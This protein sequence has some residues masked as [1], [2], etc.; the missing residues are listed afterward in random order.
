MVPLCGAGQPVVRAL[1]STEKSTS[2]R[3]QAT[4]EVPQAA[5]FLQ[6]SPF[7]LLWAASAGPACGV[8]R[9]AGA[10]LDNAVWGDVSAV[11]RRRHIAQ[12]ICQ[13]STEVDPLSRTLPWPGRGD[14]STVDA[15]SYFIPPTSWQH[16]SSKIV[17]PG[18]VMRVT[19]CGSARSGKGV[20]AAI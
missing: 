19:G 9:R 6:A 14:R 11:S 4:P 8:L 3:L 2:T 20:R 17:G 7:R 15:A 5:R 13:L 18:V 12:H 16:G 10:A 1:T